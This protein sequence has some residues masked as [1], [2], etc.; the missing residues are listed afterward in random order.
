MEYIKEIENMTVAEAVTFLANK[1]KQRIA[2]EYLHAKEQ[3]K[4]KFK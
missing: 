4:K 2:D 1:E 3:I